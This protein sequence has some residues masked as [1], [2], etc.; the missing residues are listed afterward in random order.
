MSRWLLRIA[1]FLQLG[2]AVYL[3]GTMPVIEPYPPGMTSSDR[4]F[5]DKVRLERENVRRLAVWSLGLSSIVSLSSSF[6]LRRP[7]ENPNY[8]GQMAEG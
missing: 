4:A 7:H 2:L 6:A 3:L 1:A 5:W 8:P